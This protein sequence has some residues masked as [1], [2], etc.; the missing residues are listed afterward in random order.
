MDEKPKDSNSFLL[1]IL[2]V[3]NKDILEQLPK[4]KAQFMDEKYKRT[5]DLSHH[6]LAIYIRKCLKAKRTIMEI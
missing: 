3:P 6:G 2:S 1:F 5:R 4:K